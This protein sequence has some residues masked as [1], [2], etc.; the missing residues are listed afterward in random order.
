MKIVNLDKVQTRRDVAIVLDG[1]EHVMKSPT[2]KDYIDQMKRA[3]EIGKLQQDETL[4]SASR[5]MELTIDTLMK[6]FPTVTKEQFESL[7]IEQLE[8]LRTLTEDAS[9]E[10][11]PT[12]G[13]AAGKKD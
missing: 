5:M 11:A 6:S 3:E 12:E 8:A 10:E 4:D 9:T 2:V 1:V 13:E 7:T